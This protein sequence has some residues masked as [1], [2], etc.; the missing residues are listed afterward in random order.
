VKYLSGILA[1]SALLAS[2]ASADQ[3]PQLPDP[4][5]LQASGYQAQS[6]DA[7]HWDHDVIC[8]RFGFDDFD[9]VLGYQSAL[10]TQGWRQV[11]GDGRHSP[12][13]TDWEHRHTVLW[14]E[15]PIDDHCSNVLSY[16]IGRELQR[17]GKVDFILFII[18]DYAPACDMQRQL[19]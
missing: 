9:A 16:E 6:C 12:V 17:D 19:R 15:R 14:F 8:R 4:H 13:P 1:T 11:S 18:A 10:Q 2:R 5:S 3:L 7:R